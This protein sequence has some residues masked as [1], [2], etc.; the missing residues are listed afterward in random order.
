[1]PNQLTVTYEGS[2]V[3]VLADGDKNYDFSVK[4]WTTVAEMC[5][6]H[7]CF[8]VLGI[9]N[10]TT[11]IEAVEGYDHARLFRELN[12]GQD[13]RIAW[14]ELNPDAVDIVSFIETVLVNR[15]LPG[16]LFPTVEEARYWLLGDDAT[17]S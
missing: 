8:N 11:P 13:Y 2:H 1:M 12:I 3:R 10:T 6:K 7:N 15:G 17:T 5:Q 4:L 16:R 14:V 9:A